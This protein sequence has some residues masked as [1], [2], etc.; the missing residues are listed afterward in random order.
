M[1]LERLRQLAEDFRAVSPTEFDDLAESC[2]ELAINRLD[3]R[4]MV[5]GECLRIS[6]G[7]WGDGD[8]GAVSTQFADAPARTWRDYLPGV[9][10]TESEAEG[11][12]VALALREELVLLGASDPLTYRDPRAMDE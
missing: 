11:T 2:R 8:S 7:F 9:L 5:L 6:S 1:S 12:A 3:V 4:Y 10:R